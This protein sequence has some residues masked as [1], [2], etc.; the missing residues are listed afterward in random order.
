MAEA[1]ADDRLASTLGFL[2]SARSAYVSGQVVRVG[3]AL[4]PQTGPAAD[5]DQPLDGKV[6]LVTGASRGIGAAIAETLHRD[7]AHVVG[8]D[9]PQAASDLQAVMDAIDGERV[10][11]DITAPD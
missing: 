1:G 5:A 10:S 7:G 6:A 11:L 8:V 9:V 4:S 2:L 3:T